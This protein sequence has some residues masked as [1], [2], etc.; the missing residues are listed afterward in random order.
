MTLLTSGSAA[1]GAPGHGAAGGA[2]VGGGGA[3]RQLRPRGAAA[4][5]PCELFPAR[6]PAC[7][8]DPGSWRRLALPT[9]LPPSLYTSFGFLPTTWVDPVWQEDAERA[10]VG[11][12]RRLLLVK[13]LRKGMVPPPAAAASA[14]AAAVTAG[15]AASGPQGSR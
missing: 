10:R 6:Q 4:R 9:P 7:A 14:G 3:P 13:P 11:K 12:P 2:I 15:A 1:I 5:G 8:P